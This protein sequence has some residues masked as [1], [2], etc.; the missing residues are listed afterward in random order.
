[1]VRSCKY[2]ISAVALAALWGETSQAEPSSSAALGSEPPA[3]L[4]G[5]Q[6]EIFDE[7]PDKP[8]DR[9]TEVRLTGEELAARGATDLGTALALLPDVSVRD[10]GRGGFNVDIRGARKGAVAI[11]IDGVLVTDPYYGTFD[12]STIPI[13]DIVQIRIATTPQSPIDGP[14]GPGGVI[15]VHTRDAIGDAL[16]I[17]R[18]T[19]DSL[20]SLGAT[21][22]ARF[23]LAS[24][25][26]LRLSASGQDGARDFD[27]P[28]PDNVGEQRHAGTGAGRLEYRD[29]DRRIALDGFFD[30]R[31]YVSPPSDE[32][33]ITILE[34]D[35]ETTGRGSLK[36]DDKLGDVQL[37]AEAWGQYLYRRSRSF[38]DAM[39]GD[40]IVQENLTAWRGG[41]MALV[42]QP[43]LRDFR[44]AVSTTL[45]YEQARVSNI[46]DKVTGRGDT[47][48]VE[49][50]ADLQF[51]HGVIRADVSGGV[52]VPYGIGARPWPEGKAVVKVRP[53]DSLELTATGAYKGRVPALRERF[54]SI[55]G[56]PDLGPER[57]AQGELR[58]IAHV[59]DRL[60]LE[61]A[62]FYKRSTGTIV[63][64]QAPADNGKL[65]NLG[66]VTY[67]GG[68]ALVRVTVN[69]E[70]EAGGGYEYI[71]AHSDETGDDPLDRLPHHRW[72]AWVQ[73]RPLPWINA[74]AR[75]KYYGQAFAQGVKVDGYAT[76]EASAA[77]QI[78]KA[79]LAV[80][81]VDDLMNEAP[82]TRPGVFMP[83][84]TYSLVLQ[85]QWP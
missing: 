23:P 63:S 79:Y 68:D 32:G 82:E 3:S 74:L 35:R 85:G 50:A 37:Q 28:G 36:Y 67:L 34:V 47:T 18:V 54:D 83:G 17:V 76:V 24:H 42:T 9:D 5:E 60:H 61:L 77:A 84:R 66:L 72:E 81:R 40:E 10:A 2:L 80:L 69:R 4:E 26:A 41:G 33:R 75:V 38:D 6:I 15:E 46:T 8:F 12:V 14:G 25:L 31:H 11:L 59:T 21:A 64:S 48:I 70:L 52:A 43:F 30:D 20:P 65:K 58:A 1:M 29:G 71:K 45:D 27:I 19:G 73:G 57:I 53:V 22:T 7:R 44:W 49:P 55:V 16:E 51:E 78:T 39:L 62:P 56:N 13:T